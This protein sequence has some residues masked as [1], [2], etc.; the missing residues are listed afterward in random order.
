MKTKLFRIVCEPD[1]VLEAILSSENLLDSGRYLAKKFGYK[2][3]KQQCALL[4][5]CM[6]QKLRVW[7]DNLSVPNSPIE[8]VVNE[9]V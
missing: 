1:D 9:D 7:L 3:N 5:L 4:G 8:L 6:F 2:L